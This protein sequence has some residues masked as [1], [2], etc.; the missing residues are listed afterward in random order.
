[1]AKVKVAFDRLPA[2]LALQRGRLGVPGWQSTCVDANY[3]QLPDGKSRADREQIDDLISRFHEVSRNGSLPEKG[4]VFFRCPEVEVHA[5]P[6]GC[7]AT[8]RFTYPSWPEAIAERF[9]DLGEYDLALGLGSQAV[10]DLSTMIGAEERGM[11]RRALRRLADLPPPG[12]R[13]DLR[14]SGPHI[15][16]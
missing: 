14:A 12:G 7:E 3:I 11:V 15:Y 6:Q 2:Y 9:E 4:E 13:F 16:P 5:G 10:L 8:M 1:M